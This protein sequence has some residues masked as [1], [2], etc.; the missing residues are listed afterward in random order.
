MISQEQLKKL[1]GALVRV[2][3]AANAAPINGTL[4]VVEHE[5]PVAGQSL[6]LDLPLPTGKRTTLQL[7]RAEAEKLVAAEVPE[8]KWNGK[9][10]PL[11]PVSS[12]DLLET[13]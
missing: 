11:R 7:T 2:T 10:R 1:R 9:T 8:F 13:A 6:N 12:A 5:I 4:W 3:T